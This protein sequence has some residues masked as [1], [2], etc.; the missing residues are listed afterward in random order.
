MHN[1]SKKLFVLAGETSGDLHAGLVIK[2]LKEQ[3]PDIE[4]FG[5]GG[6]QLKKAGIKLLYETHQ[7]NFMGF[8]EVA[9]HFFFL[10]KVISTI[11]KTIQ[12]EKPDAA[13]LVDY[14][15]MNLIIA[16]FLHQQ[17]IPV[18]YYI[19][20]QVWAWKEKRVQK[21]KTYVSRLLIVFLFEEEFFKA[22]GVEAEFV[23]H[24]IIE[25]LEDVSFESKQDFREKNTIMPHEKII[26]VLPGSRTQELDRIYPEMLK[27]LKRLQQTHSV[28]LLLGK[29]PNL[30][31]ERYE[32]FHQEY[33]I[34]P[35][36]VSGYETMK[37]SDVV[38]VTSGTATLETLYFGTPM[39]VLYKTNWLNYEIGKRLVKI[40]KFALANI[41]SKGLN[42]EDKLV[43]ELLQDEINAERVVKEVSGLLDNQTL[44]RSVQDQL[45]DAKTLLGE[46]KPSRE[47]TKVLM[48]VLNHRPNH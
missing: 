35:T 39:V 48:E 14:P 45:L 24:P 38:L 20:P 32:K 25:E 31:N 8:V 15:G 29:A 37:Y 34:Q 44:Y 5:V 28:K 13:L 43:P 16:E 3:Q 40:G 47:V 12:S 10:K 7:I 4:V 27:A 17:N 9:K 21:I 23:G 33:G 42:G 1:L 36:I 41:V 19:A 22:R 18:I 30:P 11:K 26:G 6:E 2:A 46:K